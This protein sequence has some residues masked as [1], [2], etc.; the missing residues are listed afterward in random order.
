MGNFF[1]RPPISPPSPATPAPIIPVP[2]LLSPPLLA[3]PPE[4]R[5][6]DQIRNLQNLPPAISND[7][8]PQN[9]LKQTIDWDMDEDAL[10]RQVVPRRNRD[11]PLPPL[12][13]A[14]GRVKTP[15]LRNVPRGRLPIPIAQPVNAEVI[16][17]QN[18]PILPPILRPV[19]AAIPLPIA[20]PIPVRRIVPP[21][22]LP[23][24]HAPPVPSVRVPRANN[25]LM[26]KKYDPRQFVASE[27]K[28]LGEGS[29]GQVYLETQRIT[30]RQIVVK[31]LSKT[32]RD[33]MPDF[34]AEVT[35]LRAIHP[36]CREYLLCYEDV[37]ED[38]KNY[39][40][41]TAYVA[42]FQPMSAAVGHPRT[43]FTGAPTA[44]AQ[45]IANLFRGLRVIHELRLAHRDIKPENILSR[46]DGQIRFIDFG[47]GCVQNTC[48]LVLPAA[49]T[50]FFL[51]PEMSFGISKSLLDY[52]KGTSGH[53]A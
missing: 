17:R 42:G 21:P 4:A 16:P 25:R 47:L 49:G 34:L 33:A 28:F 31:Q 48:K 32:V 45:S 23:A 2:L 27:R 44:F 39:Y 35:A 41:A 13:L 36:R 12:K 52:Q 24:V 14:R 37:Y 53:L 9:K 51:A 26:I 19:L 1:S 46:R 40:I 3:P 15:G 22:P 10:N 20:L 43:F 50:P 6:N 8:V 18:P 29:F 11:V 30:G 38:G 7:K 5:K